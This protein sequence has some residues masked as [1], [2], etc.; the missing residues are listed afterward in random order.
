MIRCNITNITVVRDPS[1]GTP[2]RV[3]S[4]GNFVE[5]STEYKYIKYNINKL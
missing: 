4:D 3:P 2:I 1:V 5:P